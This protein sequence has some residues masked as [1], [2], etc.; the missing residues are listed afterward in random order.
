MKLRLLLTILCSV[1][2]LAT[3]DSFASA[4]K[5]QPEPDTIITI[6]P[7]LDYRENSAKKSSKLSILGPL[8]TFERTAEDK[9]TAL[10]PLFHTEKNL[11]ATRDFTYYLYPLASSETTADVSRVEFLQVLQKNTYRK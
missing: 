3:A 2:L 4:E 6:W 1:F 5:Q 10:R 11:S 7:L 9:I 8:L